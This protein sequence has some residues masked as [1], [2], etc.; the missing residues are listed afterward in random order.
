MPTLSKAITNK[1]GLYQLLPLNK[2]YTEN[3]KSL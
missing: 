3:E 1:S 2:L